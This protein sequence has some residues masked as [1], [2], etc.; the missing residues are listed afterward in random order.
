LA[1]N[2]RKTDSARQKKSSGPT[3]RYYRCALAHAAIY[4]VNVGRLMG[5]ITLVRDI[6][7]AIQPATNAS[8]GK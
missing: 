2:L 6:A 7:G 5:R 1:N 4:T 8:I 3:I